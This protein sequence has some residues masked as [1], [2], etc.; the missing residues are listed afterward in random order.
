MN[1]LETLSTKGS[2]LVFYSITEFI[3]IIVLI[4]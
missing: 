1:S 4:N 3:F 2:K